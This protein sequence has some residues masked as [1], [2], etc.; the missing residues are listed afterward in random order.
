LGGE[1]MELSNKALAV[2]LL[3]AMVISL[4]GTIISLNRMS[5]VQTVGYASSAVGQIQ[6]DIGNSVSIT[7]VDN[8]AIDFG[9]CTPIS[10][11]GIVANVTSDLLENTT[12]VC[13]GFTTL[14]NIS[15][16]NDGNT[17]VSVT[18]QA[19][20]CAPGSGNSSCTFMN[21]TS[22]GA[23]FMYKTVT[24]GGLGNSGALNF[25]NGCL[26][27]MINAYTSFTGTHSGLAGCG[28]LMYGLNNN[29][30][31]THF[32]IGVPSDAPLG[33]GYVNVTYTAS[34]NNS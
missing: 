8:N 15:V 23:L 32:K 6:L 17:N 19:S 5:S 34:V 3:A 7:T 20:K 28:K 18:L 24:G 9:S 27:G 22:G 11:A 29:S 13:P 25:S 30:F 16:R 4:G 33:L 14:D 26:V 10:G 2:L 12:T 21:S 1:K 31:V